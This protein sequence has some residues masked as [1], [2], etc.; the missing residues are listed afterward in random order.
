M[1]GLVSDPYTALTMSLIL[2]FMASQHSTD[3][4]PLSEGLATISFFEAYHTL[5]LLIMIT[6]P[7]T[8][9]MEWLAQRRR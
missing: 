7:L 3:M 2:A 1:T 4:T 8:M 9:C 6:F 5:A